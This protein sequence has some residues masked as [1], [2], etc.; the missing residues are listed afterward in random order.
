VAKK[1][2]AVSGP[3]NVL[4]YR[5]PVGSIATMKPSSLDQQVRTRIDSFVQELSA[6]VRQAAIESVRTAL[7]AG[8]APA[9]GPGRPRGTSNSAPTA[10]VK[11]KGGKRT[12][13]D[14]A[15][16]AELVLG[17]VKTN[18]GQRLEQMARGLKMST[19]D[20]KLPVAK[21][22]EA[23][24]LSTKGQKRGTRYFTR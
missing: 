12:P 1:H 11:R 5:S 16:A 14:V 8:P 6:L 4:D 21:L 7:G 24:K 17:Y 9:R 20:L 13:E 18:A 22:M 10:S 23:K 2:A 19:K 3:K 15:K